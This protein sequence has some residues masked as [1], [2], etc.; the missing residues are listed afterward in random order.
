MDSIDVNAF[1]TPFQLT[2]SMHRDIYASLEPSNPDLNASGKVVLITG[3]GGKLGGDTAFA[4]ATAR[5]DGIILVGRG[6]EDLKKTAERIG[7]VG[8]SKVLV[9]SCDTTS[10]T[11]V[12]SLF[13]DIGKHFDKLDV[14]I[15]CAGATNIGLIGDTEPSFW[16]ENFET[17]VKGPYLMIHYFIKHFGEVGTII[18]ISSVACTAVHP[19]MSSYA[20]TKLAVNRVNECLQVEH[21]SLRVFSL[22]PGNV[23]SKLTNPDF[24]PFAIDSGMLTG[25]MTLYL[26]TP[27]A[28]YLKGGLCSVN[29]DVEEMETHRDEIVDKGLLK[30][31]F[32]NAKLGPEG[33]PWESTT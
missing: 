30:T 27:R 25:G 21:P 7:A 17:N 18:T 13:E 5:A 32:L 15:N 2:K 4:W 31:A 22:M 28:D 14:L 33:H 23:L 10:E 12:K 19:G 3:G 11:A 26:S 9:R 29:W 24:A 20:A 6:M 8:S 1:T 16:W